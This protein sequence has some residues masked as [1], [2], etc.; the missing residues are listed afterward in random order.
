MTVTTESL[1]NAIAEKLQAEH[2]EVVDKSGGCG[3]IFEVVIVSK[4]FE[5]KPLLARHRLVNDML[6]EE[7]A[8]MHA[9]SQKSYTPEQWSQ[10]QKN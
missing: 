7:I 3:Q 1:H 5:G 10:M 9:F 2:V 4:M 8:S 6:K